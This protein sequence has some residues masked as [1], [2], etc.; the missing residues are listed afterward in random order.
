MLLQLVQILVLDEATANVDVE[1]DALIQVT[2]AFDILRLMGA[3]NYYH[4]SASSS[5]CDFVSSVLVCNT[6]SYRGHLKSGAKIAVQ[7]A[8]YWLLH[9][10]VACILKSSLCVGDRV[11]HLHPISSDLCVTSCSAKWK[12]TSAYCM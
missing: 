3:S 10:L 4:C 12:W 8:V 6:A 9:Q 7:E 2:H 1:T 11:Y 5:R